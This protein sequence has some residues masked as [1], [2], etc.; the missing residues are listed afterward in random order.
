MFLKISVTVVSRITGS[1]PRIIPDFTWDAMLKHTCVK[2]KLLTD[3]VIERG[4]RGI[5][6]LSQCSNRYTRANNKYIVVRSIET[7]DLMYFDVNNLYGWAM[8]QPLSYADFRWINNVE[9]LDVTV[10]TDSPTGYV[11]E[12]D[13]EYI[14]NIFTML[15]QIYHSV[16]RARN[17]PTSEKRSSSLHCM[18]RSVI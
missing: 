10:A 5:G 9:N 17:H 8:C 6:D 7:V 16:Q 4:I 18:I 2:F 13:L 14:R 1:I 12:I 3:M 15:T 11:L